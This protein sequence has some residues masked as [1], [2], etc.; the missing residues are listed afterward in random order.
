MAVA[1]H[2][3][4]LGAVRDST[5]TADRQLVVDLGREVWMCPVNPSVEDANLPNMGCWE[6]EHA[7][8]RE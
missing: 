5:D 4:I 2:P 1:I 3:R 7:N 6:A 8:R